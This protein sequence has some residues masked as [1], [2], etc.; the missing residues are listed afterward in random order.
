MQKKLAG[1]FTALALVLA[2]GTVFAQGKKGGKKGPAGPGLTLTT[3]AWPD[4]GEVPAQY[5][6]VGG[7]TSPAL[8]WSHVPAGTQSFV[9]LFHDPDVALQRKLNDVTHWIV[10]NIPGD[11]TSLPEGLKEGTTLPDGAVQGK[12]IRGQ[13][14]YMGPGAPSAGP[15]HHYTLALFALDEKLDLGP[16]A[17]REEVM[18]ALNGHIL[19]KAIY[20]G[21]YKQP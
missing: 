18:N 12:N 19:G 4:G 7:S 13:N 15:Q 11:A 8:E 10:W 3:S 6:M 20:V 9:L 2:T 21:R 14:A 1:L 5:S 17:S 16:N